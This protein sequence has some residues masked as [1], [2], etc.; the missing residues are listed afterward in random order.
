VV[1]LSIAVNCVDRVLL[2]ALPCPTAATAARTSDDE[3]WF[4]A[5][6]S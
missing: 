1:A 5:A 4:L 3:D 6:F 2:S